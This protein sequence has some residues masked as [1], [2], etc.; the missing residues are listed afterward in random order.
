MIPTA[1][2]QIITSGPQQTAAF[3]E[4]LG[5]I[6]DSGDLYL[7]S[8]GLGAGKTCLT[9]GVAAGLGV[10]DPVTSPTF[11]LVNVYDGRLRLYH[12]DLYRIEQASELDELGLEE[13]LES[14]A[15]IVVEWAE[16]AEA[17]WPNE[18]L[19]IMLEPLDGNH[20]R[21]RCH[22]VGARY[23]AQLER[24]RALENAARDR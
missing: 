20:R 24:L 9:Q 12:V 23:A 6:A 10:V 16:R 14:D 3:G 11:T 5:R 4:Q 1:T 7:L 19:D 22:A 8:G 21:I 13:L 15:V 18:R 2:L 17:F